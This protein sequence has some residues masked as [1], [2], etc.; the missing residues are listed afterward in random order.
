MFLTFT[1]RRKGEKYE[2]EESV[3]GSDP[4]SKRVVHCGNGAN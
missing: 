1:K 3:S 4:V 2:A